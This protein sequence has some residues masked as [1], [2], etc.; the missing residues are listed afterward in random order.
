MS[1]WLHIGESLSVSGRTNKTKMDGQRINWEKLNRLWDLIADRYGKDITAGVFEILKSAFYNDRIT[2]SI[3]HMDRV[4]VYEQIKEA[5]G[6]GASYEELSIR[7]GK[8]VRHIRH[9][10]DGHPHRG[11]KTPPGKKTTLGHARTIIPL[12][13]FRHPAKTHV[14]CLCGYTNIYITS[15]WKGNKHNKC[16][17]CAAKINYETREV[18]KHT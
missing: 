11:K 10:V 12:K 2:I 9:I 16:R 6:R 13:K 18:Y 7:F 15:S 14:K 8:G 1:P 3:G 5:A 4:I 17:Q